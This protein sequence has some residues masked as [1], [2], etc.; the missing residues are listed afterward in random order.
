MPAYVMVQVDVRDA[1]AYERYKEL[2]PPAIS[3]YGGRYLARGG[4]TET[5][6]GTWRPSRFVILEFPDAET[7]RAWWRSPEYAEAKAL[8]HRSATSEMLLVEGLPEGSTRG[9]AR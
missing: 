3:A 7:A 4:V 5:L 6:E 9:G 2:A 8:R 1:A